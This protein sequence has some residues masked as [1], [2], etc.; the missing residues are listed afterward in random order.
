MLRFWAALTLVVMAGAP[1]VRV[2]DGHPWAFVRAY[3]FSG[4]VAH[5]ALFKVDVAA[6][7]TTLADPGPPD[8]ADWLVDQ[9]GD[10]VAEEEYGRRDDTWR[11]K[12]RKDGQWRAIK[13]LPAK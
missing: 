1:L 8:T 5:L 12:V 9:R 3:Y 7:R 11:L 2:V 10:V 4:N 13:A 6:A